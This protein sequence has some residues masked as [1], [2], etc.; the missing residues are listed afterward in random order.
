[1]QQ[2][3]PVKEI[4]GYNV[5]MKMGLWGISSKG[6]KLHWIVLIGFLGSQPGS[7]ESL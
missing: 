2:Y 1:M 4:H 5:C 6:S 7:R 3:S